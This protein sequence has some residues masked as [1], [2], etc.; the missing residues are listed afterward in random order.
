MSLYRLAFLHRSAAPEIINGFRSSNERL[1]YLGDAVLSSVIADFLF[2]KY[3]LKDEGFL[4]EMRSKIVSRSQLNKLS[5]KLGFN[6]LILANQ[7][8]GNVYRSIHGD[9]FEAVIGAIYLDK[10]YLF[11]KKIITSRIIKCHIDIEA[12]EKFEFSYKSTLLELAQKEKKPLEFVVVEES[13]KGYQ[14]QYTVEVFYDNQKISKAYGFSIKEAEQNAAE[15]AYK[16]LNPSEPTS[17]SY[18]C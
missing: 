6:K 11:T 12:L 2:H 18:S 17:T 16:Q 7:E 15:I 14:K 9:T 3:P 4:T 10:G 8:N 13:G 5:Q 1:E